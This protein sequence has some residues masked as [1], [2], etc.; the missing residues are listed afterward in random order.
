MV[1]LL[2]DSF[3]FLSLAGIPLAFMEGQIVGKLWMTALALPVIY[4][5]RAVDKRRG[6]VPVGA[7]T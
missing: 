5:L 2:V 4:W 6:L 7:N 3:V 1:G